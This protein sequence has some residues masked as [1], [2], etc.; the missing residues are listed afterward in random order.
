MDTQQLKEIDQ[1]LSVLQRGGLILYPTDTVW[2]IGCDATNE[3]SV[4]KIYTLKNR[5]DSKA[6]I[7]L[8]SDGLMLEKHV[9]DIPK[10][11]YDLMELSEKP[12]TIIFDNPLGVATNLMASD[13]SLAIRVARD[14]F[15]QYLVRRLKKPL[16]STS[17]N[18]SGYPTPAS[19][20]EISMEILTGVDYV[21]N[22]ER[23]TIKKSPSSI[24][25]LGADGTVKVIRE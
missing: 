9:K 16:V 14:P 20:K 10:V 23:H 2:G 19:F 8:V 6:M 21:V 11:A 7:C 12:I 13:N 22:L 25:K 4:A 24:I 5:E 18:L 3:A 1:C 17:A 15:C